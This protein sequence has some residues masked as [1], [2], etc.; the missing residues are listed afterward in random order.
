MCKPTNGV[1]AKIKPSGI[2]LVALLVG[3]FFAQTARAD[4]PEEQP[5][6]RAASL[7]YGATALIDGWSIFHNQAAMAFGNSPWVG[8]HH[9]NRFITPEL[10]FSALGAS[11]PVKVGT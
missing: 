10:A 2:I 7:G 4:F 8:V 6:S 5:G 1:F 11:I 9:E 3:V